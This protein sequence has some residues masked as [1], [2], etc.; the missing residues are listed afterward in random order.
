MVA[1][2]SS[3]SA[4]SC[5]RSRRIRSTRRR[6]VT[7]YWIDCP[8]FFPCRCLYCSSRYLSLRTAR[9]IARRSRNPRS[10]A[11]RLEYLAPRSEIERLLV[12]IWKQTLGVEKPGLKDNFFDLGGHSLLLAQVQSRL[13]QAGYEVSMLD[14]LRNPTIEAVAARLNQ[15]QTAA[16]GA[17]VGR[18]KTFP[19]RREIAI[20]GIAGRFPKAG[21]VEEFWQ[22]LSRGDECISFFTDEELAEAGIAAGELKDPNYVKAAGVLEGAEL[23]DAPF[24]GFHPREAELMDPQ[25]RIFLQ[26][27]WHALEDAGYDPARYAGRIGVFGGAGLNTYLFEVGPTL[28]NSSAL[29][30]QAFIGN[31]KDFLTTRVSYKLNLKG[32]SVDVQTACSTS[33]VAV[34]LACQSLLAGECEMALA[35]G[36]AIRAPLKQGYLYEEGGILSP[37][38]HCRAFDKN[39]KGTVFGNGAGIVVLKPLEKA[40]ADGDNIYA[41]IKGSA[42][43]NDGSVKLGYTAPSVDGQAEVISDAFAVSGSILKPL[44]TSRPTELE[45]LWEIRLRSQ[46]FRKPFAAAKRGNNSAPSVP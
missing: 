35:G 28:S 17:R 23:F 11:R 2:N 8:I 32:P 12:E 41:V 21:N 1:G 33:L 3:L 37:D 25:H 9:S 39:A 42:I 10:S 7:L 18:S 15:E 34:H 5:R 36:V 27:A 20:V 29:R 22:R 14:L 19:A 43:N 38:A 44:R 13:S 16:P 24:F 4:T 45:R 6:F 30:Y 46:P 40:L 26:C 31:D